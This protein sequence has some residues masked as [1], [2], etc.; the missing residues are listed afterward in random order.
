[1]IAQFAQHINNRQMVRRSQTN[2]A[3]INKLLYFRQAAPQH[4]FIYK[5]RYS[6]MQIQAF[7]A[8]LAFISSSL[9]YLLFPIMSIPHLLLPSFAFPFR[10]HVIT[11]ATYQSF[12]PKY[13]VNTLS[14]F[15]LIKSLTTIQHY[16]F[17]IS[18][19]TSNRMIT[20]AK[21]QQQRH[22]TLFSMQ[23]VT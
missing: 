5:L 2:D 21:N 15:M 13:Q 9:L 4:I 22:C 16:S 8:F 14:L 18:E 10:F 3:I 19:K 7:T 6:S 20:Y 23:R 12:Q 1:M 11:H 17:S